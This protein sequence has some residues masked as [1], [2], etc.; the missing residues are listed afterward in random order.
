MFSGE[1]LPE[2]KIT[3]LY[4]SGVKQEGVGDFSPKHPVITV[5]F[6]SDWVGVMSDLA[7]GRQQRTILFFLM[8]YSI[9]ILTLQGRCYTEASTS[10]S[11]HFPLHK[12]EDAETSHV[13]DTESCCLNPNGKH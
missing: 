3:F 2:Y 11:L 13:L 6:A 5:T 8:P 7:L 12:G 4:G 10:R 1:D 9:R